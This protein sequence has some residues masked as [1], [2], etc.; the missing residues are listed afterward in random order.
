MKEQLIIL[1][2]FAGI[3]TFS[4]AFHS[5][6][7]RFVTPVFCEIDPDAQRVLRKNF[8]KA[9]IVGDVSKLSYSNGVLYFDGKEIYRGRIDIIVGGFPCTDISVAGKQK[10]LTD[11]EGKSTRSGL[12]S[13]YKR[14]IKEIVPK[15][16]LIENVRALLGNGIGTVLKDIS[17]VG[18][19]AEW[20][21]ISARDVGQCH[22][23]ERLWI[24]A[25]PNND[26]RLQGLPI[27]T[28]VERESIQSGRPSEDGSTTVTNSRSFGLVQREGQSEEVQSRRDERFQCEEGEQSSLSES[29]HS[30]DSN[31]SETSDS[32]YFRFW[33]SFTT[34]E[35]KSQWWSK[36][37]SQ[38]RSWRK[39]QPE[40]RGV[41][42][43]PT[44][45]LHE[46]FRRARIKQLGNG[47]VRTIATLHA[48]RIVY[49]EWS[50]EGQL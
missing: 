3:G 25:Y 23:R 6:D 21:V 2:I 4:Y 45:G 41:Y 44:T 20:E 50:D 28:E 42:D 11:E 22:L 30:S 36:A 14:L 43:G 29:L 15:Y 49:H 10:G 7:K 8:P 1:E 46:K 32:N 13:E 24:V 17:E 39:T 9:T 33:P 18:Y 16:V 47:I 38:F 19:D 37:T 5:R 12:W 27:P 26:R 34:P 35:E 40:L 31:G 48:E